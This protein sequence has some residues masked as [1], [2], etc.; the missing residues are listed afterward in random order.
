MTRACDLT[1]CVDWSEDEV[2]YVR[3]DILRKTTSIG[4]VT[5]KE[6]LVR[7]GEHTHERES[8]EIS[9]RYIE[10]LCGPW[11]KIRLSC[12]HLQAVN[13]HIDEKHT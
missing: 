6:K 7:C 4:H 9:S 12:V 10:V 2:T 8:L 5:E 3:D 11:L 13:F 1:Y